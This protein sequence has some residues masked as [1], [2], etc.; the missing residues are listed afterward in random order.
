MHCQKKIITVIGN[1]I[2]WKDGKNL[3]FFKIQ[4]A[5]RHEKHDRTTETLFEE[6]S[7]TNTLKQG[8]TDEWP[9]SLPPR[10][11]ITHSEPSPFHARSPNHHV[12]KVPR[13][14]LTSITNNANTTIDD[15]GCILTGKPYASI[16]AEGEEE[17]G[18]LP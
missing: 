7:E 13:I 6:E 4:R 1:L 10:N 11:H 2:N 3:P 14:K 9:R 12:L 15:D 8:P 17:H 5:P 16:F 18:G